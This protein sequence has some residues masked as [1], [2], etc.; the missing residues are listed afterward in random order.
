M[1]Q[2]PNWF[3]TSWSAVQETSALAT[4]FATVQ[5]AVIGAAFDSCAK[6]CLHLEV[7]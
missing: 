3:S 5:V 7:R 4:A 6:L 2:H 1:H